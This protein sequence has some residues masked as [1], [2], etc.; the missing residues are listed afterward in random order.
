MAFQ[1]IP[2]VRQAVELRNTA[3]DAQAKAD[4]N[5]A[6]LYFTAM[7]AGIDLPEDE[8]ESGPENSMEVDSDD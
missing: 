5:E 3:A 2:L 4:A 8:A 7:M 1:Y 6:N